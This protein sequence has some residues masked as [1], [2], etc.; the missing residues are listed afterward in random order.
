MTRTFD[1]L[2]KSVYIAHNVNHKGQ[3]FHIWNMCSV[4]QNLSVVVINVEH[5]TLDLP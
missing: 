1:L 2:L 4:K 5:V 3:C